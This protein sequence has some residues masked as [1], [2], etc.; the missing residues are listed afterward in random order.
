[1]TRSSDKYAVRFYPIASHWHQIVG[2]HVQDLEVQAE[3]HQEIESPYV[4]GVPLTE[5]QD[6]F[7]GRTDISAHIEQLVMER[8]CPPLLLYGQRRTGKTSILKNLGRLLPNKIISMFVDLQGPVRAAKGHTGF[9]YNLA[10]GNGDLCPTPR[11][12]NLA[13]TGQRRPGG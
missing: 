4:I 11:R 13:A 7:V 2:R 5:Q 1:M 6:I 9:L 3:Q 8:R 12:I 10:R